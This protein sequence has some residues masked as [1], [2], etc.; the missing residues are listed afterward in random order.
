METDTKTSDDTK[1]TQ[2]KEYET[3]VNLKRNELIVITGL[4]APINKYDSIYNLCAFIINKLSELNASNFKL[5][6]F[7]LYISSFCICLGIQV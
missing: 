6:G 3:T 5:N 7:H 4:S 1:D 2:N